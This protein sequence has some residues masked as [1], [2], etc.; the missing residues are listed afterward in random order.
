MIEYIN[1]HMRFGMPFTILSHSLHVC[2]PYCIQFFFH[3][4]CSFTYEF[5]QFLVLTII[6][7]VCHYILATTLHAA[8]Y[9]RWRVI[10]TGGFATSFERLE[11]KIFKQIM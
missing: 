2:N 1:S 10:H 11:H 4:F 3:I 7:S 9:D 6:F 5:F 8:F